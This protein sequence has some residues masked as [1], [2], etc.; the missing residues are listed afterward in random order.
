MKE[1]LL[2]SYKARCV[3]VV[4]IADY[5]EVKLLNAHEFVMAVSYLDDCDEVFCRVIEGGFELEY[6]QNT[7]SVR[8]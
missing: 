2:R 4:D 7:Y 6:I 8:V 3:Q 5:P 1:I